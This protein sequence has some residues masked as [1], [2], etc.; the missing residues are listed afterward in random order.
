VRGE[1]YTC[2]LKEDERLPMM[3]MPDAI[4]AT[5]ELMEAPREQVRERG[6]YNLAAVSF[7]PAEI[8]AAIRLR[9]PEFEV[10]YAPDYRQAIAQGWPDSIDD[11]AARA[12]W[13]WQP[14][15]GLQE[16]VDDMLDNLR[17]SLAVEPAPVAPVATAV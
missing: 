2:F 6:S 1:P 13:G 17:K 14:R 3:Y 8:A 15:F 4:R 10:R 9:V 7:T 5:L 16:M 11:S 12:D